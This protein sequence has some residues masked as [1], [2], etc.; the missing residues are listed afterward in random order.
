MRINH[1]RFIIPFIVI[2]TFCFSCN[3]KLSTSLFK[4]QSP[5]QAY[6][7]KLK[8][9]G[10][11]GSAIFNKWSRAADRSLAQPIEISIPYLEKAYF[12]SESPE[13]TAFI[14]EAQ[15][16]EQLHVKLSLQSLDS[17]I[18]FIDLFEAATD[19]SK[20]HKYLHSLKKGETSLTYNINE[21]GKYMLRIQ[22]ELLSTVSYEL[23]VTAAPSLGN[24][25]AK[26]AKQHIGSLFGVGRDE[27]ERK[28]EGIDIF[29]ARSTPAV[30]AADG[31]ISRTGNN[32][33][34]GNV[35]FLKPKGRSINLYYAHL[36]SQLVVA[37]QVV[38]LGDTIGLIGNTGNARTT[39]PHL[40]FGIYTSKGA[41]DPLPFVSSGKMIPSKIVANT[42][43]IGDTVRIT[44]KNGRIAL[45]TPVIIEAATQNGYRVILP[46]KSK[47]FL[48][49][50]E[51]SPVVNPLK[52][53]ILQQSKLLYREPNL[54]AAVITNYE[55][56]T[57]LSVIG[58]YGG[59]YFVEK[60]KTRGWIA[61]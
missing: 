19:T 41:V 43:Q 60:D 49:Q 2:I 53:I 54:M 13:A 1:A 3:D 39:A 15:N 32:N 20:Q 34:G 46:D 9:A 17:P 30:A 61:Q 22:P 57:N 27:G 47:T 45:N 4:R 31:I 55:T 25:V 23:K 37:G 6:E 26:A 35:V 50:K 8:D 48:L 7:Q 51:V 59:F 42:K 16:G 11:S 5:H 28:H 40:H 10:L 36:D 52:T 14:F 12:S 38:T 18:L 58:N 29:A 24:P 21:N 56:G 44:S 33:L